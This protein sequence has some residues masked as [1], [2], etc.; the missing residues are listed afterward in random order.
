MFD[1]ESSIN[2]WLKSFNKHRAFNHGSIREMEL[3]L[4]DHIDD[5]I[6]EGYE[7]K[8]AFELA[9]KEFGEVPKMAKEE[10]WNIKAKTTFMS[11]IRTT[12]LKNYFKT[13]TRNMLK[14]PMSSFINI[15]G[16]AV[17]IGV[18]LVVFSFID[19]NQKIDG[20]HENKEE[21]YLLTH[22]VDKEGTLEQYGQTP[23]PLA[24]MLREDFSQIESVCRLEDRSIVLKYGDNVFFENVRYADPE[25]LELFT[26]PLKWGSPKS[27]E[28]VNSIILSEKMAIKYFGEENPV[29]KNILMKFSE[30]KGKTFLISGVAEAF[31]K[32]HIIE[33]DFLI[34]F[35]NFQFSEPNYNLNDW[36]GSVNATLIQ[37][38]NP[39]DIEIIKQNMDK[40]LELRNQV[41]GSWSFSSFGF[42]QLATLHQR[43][44]NI[45]GDIGGASFIEGI[46]TLPIIAAFML[47]LACFNYINIAIVSAAKRLKEIGLRKVIGASRRLVI[48]QFLA[49]NV[50]I[51]FFATALGFIL[52]AGLFLPW[53][54]QLASFE[55]ELALSN[56][57]LWVFLL[58]IV[59]FTGIA[60][61][62]Y[63]AFYISRFSVIKIFKGSVKFGKKNPMT[64]LFLGFQ[65]I[66]AC[67]TI[68]G[69]V[70][71]TQNSAYQKKRSW[72]YDKEQTLYTPVSNQS[73]F[74]KLAAEMIKNPN[75][76]SLAGS[77]NHLG[78]SVSSSIIQMPDKK[79]QVK[80]LSVAPNYFKTMGIELKEGRLFEEFQ[81]SDKQK[82]IINQLLA[83][84]M[85][86]SQP[87][88]QTLKIDS[89]RYDIL[90]VV[91][92]F[93][94]YNFYYDLQPAIFKVS[95]DKDFR[96]LSMKVK[97]GYQKDVNEALQDQWAT[98]FPETPFQGGFQEDVWVSFFEDMDV[99][100][101]FMRAVAT[102]AIMLSGL[103]LYG[104]V[105]LNVTGRIKEFSIRK[106]LGAEIK[107]I[108]INI[109][110]QYSL[111]AGIALLIAAPLSYILI[112]ANLDMLFPDP[113][114]M[115]FGNITLSIFILISVLL[116]VISTQIRK[117]SKSNPVEGLKGE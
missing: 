82:V 107:H 8:V 46:I 2:K 117:V 110:N 57:K 95:E 92:D 14:N 19:W 35:E 58:S 28:D 76:I 48:F 50:F 101:Q 11:A 37:V 3:H 67:I 6:S 49:E 64:K 97:K 10:Y 31:P 80:Q 16:L 17:A 104:L 116:A 113:I 96:F 25:F 79:Y 32:A 1:L 106:A 44:G 61:G 45:R 56:V 100:Q 78:E 90:G 60:S 112:K 72:G 91:N 73:D 7:E 38:K 71:F 12:L 52:A 53:F 77:R 24:K 75:V 4:R 98:L 59:L 94:I 27:L 55:L 47:I 88:G 102:L 99:Q 108:A 115:G 5:M 84:N 21:I 103:G 9:V 18:S 43:T 63:P 23:T 105:T 13:T 30:D 93:H 36:K 41:K 34:N 42:E 33:F 114:P 26:F 40:Y 65:I 70:V 39:T 15:F 51:T 66:L 83:T 62:I 87:I 111:L 109:F 89:I 81:E 29:G 69:G 86:L 54:N 85:K 20:F 68:T 22:F 74:E